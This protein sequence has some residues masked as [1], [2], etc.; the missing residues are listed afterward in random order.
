MLQGIAGARVEDKGL[1][2]SVHYRQ[3]ADAAVEDVRRA[4]HAVLAGSNHPFQLT[5]GDKVYEIRPR[6]YWNKGTAVEWIQEQLDQPGAQAIYVGD[7]TTDE[8]AFA[9]LPEG[10]T[11]KVGSALETAAQF[12]LQDPAEVCHFLEWLDDRRRQRRPAPAA[13]FRD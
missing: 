3:V 5:S 11:I 4:V 8:D 13:N 7:D 9:A 10:I 6:V 1:T 12:R 2:V